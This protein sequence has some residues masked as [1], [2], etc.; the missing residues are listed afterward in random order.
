MVNDPDAW[1]QLDSFL[2]L[3]LKEN[4]NEFNSQCYRQQVDRRDVEERQK[5]SLGKDAQLVYATDVQHC[6]PNVY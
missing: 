4:E 5:S 1:I 6:H 2:D 3:V